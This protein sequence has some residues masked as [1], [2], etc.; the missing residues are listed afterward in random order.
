MNQE[1]FNW[2]AGPNYS[3]EGWFFPADM[4][5]IAALNQIQNDLGL[6]G[7]ICEVGVYKGKSITFLSHLT[8]P[9]EQLYGFDLFEDDHKSLTL[10]AIKDHG[11]EVTPVLRSCDT[12]NLSK[13][14]LANDFG[15]DKLRVLHI[16]AGH[17]YYE[18]IKTM[19][20]FAPHLDNFG[21]IIMDDYQD[22]EF[23][24]IEAAT[25]DFCQIDRPRRFVPFFSGAN[26]M[27]LCCS[28]MAKIYQTEIIKNRTIADNCRATVIKD[29]ILIKG[30]S[31]LP[32]ETL[33][34][35]TQLHNFYEKNNHYKIESPEISTYSHAF[36]QKNFG[37]EK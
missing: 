3:I 17:E 7:S 6:K 34:V 21:I 4:L 25:L 15:D 2:F 24:G 20:D 16:D 11:G 36:S 26:K 1:I 28:H 32:Q 10:K 13:K 8:K 12:N 30:F 18:V 37:W 5:S 19:M 27:F 14:Q 22:P 35:K 33:K 29:F 23:P 9:G 31:K